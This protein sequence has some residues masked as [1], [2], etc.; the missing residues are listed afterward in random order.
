MKT[1]KT[2]R[3][4]S[5]VRRSFAL[6][7]LVLEEAARLAPPELRGNWNRLVRTALEQFII[8][9]KRR[10]FA[11]G[12]AEMAKDPQALEVNRRISEEF[13]A[14]ERDGIS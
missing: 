7:K 5:V 10:R 6:P 9:R 14:A 4:S 2:K 1:L 3:G 13:A 8:Q 12:M 11:E